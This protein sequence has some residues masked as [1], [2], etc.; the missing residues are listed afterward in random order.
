MSVEA[1]K[2]TLMP[3][4]LLPQIFINK[5]GFTRCPLPPVEQKTATEIFRWLHNEDSFM[6]VLKVLIPLLLVLLLV[7]VLL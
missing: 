6:Y 3:I 2:K 7:R 1:V 4:S 5:I